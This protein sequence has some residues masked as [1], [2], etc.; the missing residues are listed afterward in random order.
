[1][2]EIEPKDQTL[3]SLEGLH[4][5]HAPLSSCSQRVRIALAETGREFASHLVNLESGEHAC[6]D[7]Q[8][9]HP[10]GL[11]PALVDDGHV[12]IESIDIIQHIAG[13]ASVLNSSVSPDV[14]EKADAAQADLKLLTFEFLFRSGPPK[15][16]EKARAFQ[17]KHRNESLK[18]FY[19]DF[20]VGFDR[21]R[22]EQ[23]VVRTK[24]GFEFL[25]NILSDGRTYLSGESFTLSDIAWIPNFHRFDLMGWPFDRTQHLSRWFDRVSKRP[26]YVTALQEWEN[27]D[28]IGTFRQY[29]ERRRAAG[30]DIRTFGGL[31]ASNNAGPHRG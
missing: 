3:K 17:A 6:G 7:Y 1:M 28:A 25:D 31:S 22:I 11:V 18:S 16:D 15:S 5:W 10:K 8:S 2:A 19:R 13:G 21:G 26:S 9:I 30:T 27:H 14:L 23:A 24:A 12:F 20:A 29:T 4:L